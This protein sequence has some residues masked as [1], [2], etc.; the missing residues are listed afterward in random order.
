VPPPHGEKDRALSWVWT[1]SRSLGA[2][3]AAMRHAQCGDYRDA[4]TASY[5]EAPRRAIDMCTT[6]AKPEPT[7]EQAP[8][9]L[10]SKTNAPVPVTNP[11]RQ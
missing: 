1:P 10:R 11:S 7:E 3:P 5:S 9:R 2:S 8:G 6:P 4:E